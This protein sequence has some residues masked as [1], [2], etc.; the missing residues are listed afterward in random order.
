MSTIYKQFYDYLR[1]IRL[2]LILNSCNFLVCFS[3]IYSQDVLGR[4]W[5]SEATSTVCSLCNNS[6]GKCI[7]SNWKPTPF[8]HA[9]HIWCSVLAVVMQCA[10]RV[11]HAACSSQSSQPLINITWFS[12]MH[13][14]RRCDV[15]KAPLKCS[16]ADRLRQRQRSRRNSTQLAAARRHNMSA[17]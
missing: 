9:E 17:T 4:L 7:G 6:S 12:D 8:Q 13:A 3:E 10:A 14:A 2:I 16:H 1:R 15:E 11:Q 5:W